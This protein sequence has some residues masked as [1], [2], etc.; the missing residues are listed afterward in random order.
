MTL[1]DILK[2]FELPL[3]ALFGLAVISGAILLLPSDVLCILG[4]N[5]LPTTWRTILG[6]TYLFSIVMW[7]LRIFIKTVNLLENLYFKSVF[8]R[9]F[10]SNMRNLTPIEGAIIVG[11][12]QEPTYTSR[13]PMNDGVILRL[14]HKLMIQP[15]MTDNLTDEFMMIPFTLTPV[16]LK[17][18]QDHPDFVEKYTTLNPLS[19]SI[20]SEGIWSNRD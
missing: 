1:K 5:Q 18:V 2:V 13:L 19:R 3:S 12:S 6:I 7:S 14:R 20:G 4:L 16:A 8:P 15:T 10:D 9:K 11:L 17:Y